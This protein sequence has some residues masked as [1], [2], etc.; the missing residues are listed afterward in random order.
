MQVLYAHIFGVLLGQ[1]ETMWGVLGAALIACGVVSVSR[2][3]SALPASGLPGPNAVKDPS[4]AERGHILYSPLAWQISHSAQGAAELAH[5]APAG[6]S[7][8]EGSIAA[9]RHERQVPGWTSP[10]G[11]PPLKG[12]MLGGK[13]N[14]SSSDALHS[15]SPRWDGLELQKRSLSGVDPGP[16]DSSSSV[17]GMVGA[18][19]P[20]SSLVERAANGPVEGAARHLPVGH[21][22]QSGQGVSRQV[23]TGVDRG[24]TLRDREQSWT[25][26]WVFEGRKALDAPGSERRSC[27]Y[28]EQE[29]V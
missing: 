13:R 20:F 22:A 21:I 12:G 26:E 9:L 6:A 23:R 29:Q 10:L 8:D 19:K 27:T 5:A 28:K 16:L 14:S 7:G 2:A 24:Q 3:K 11:M 4:A 15:T 25:G 18:G 1:P 17:A